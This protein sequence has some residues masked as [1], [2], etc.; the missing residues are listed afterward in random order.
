MGFTELCYHSR[1]YFQETYSVFVYEN[2]TYD[3]DVLLAESTH[4]HLNKL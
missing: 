2:F 1:T 3:N 4:V